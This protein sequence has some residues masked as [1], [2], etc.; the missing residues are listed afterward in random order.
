MRFKYVWRMVLWLPVVIVKLIYFLMGLIIVPL[1]MATGSKLPDMWRVGKGRPYTIWEAAIRNPVGGFGYIFEPPIYW[2][3]EGIHDPDRWLAN[4]AEEH[5]DLRKKEKN[6]IYRW[7]WT[8][9]MI[10]Y[11]RVWLWNE[12]HYGEIYFGWKLGSDPDQLDFATSF[13]PYVKGWW[14]K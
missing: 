5:P 14:K 1:F 2:N 3:T 10:S 13:R 7:R 4:V 8:G 6:T 9:W 12:T 11:R